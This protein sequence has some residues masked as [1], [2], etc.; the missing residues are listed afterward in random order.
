VSAREES[1]KPAGARREPVPDLAEGARMVAELGIVAGLPLW[2]ALRAA[3]ARLRGGA[4]VSEDGALPWRS[5]PRPG[6]VP[7]WVGDALA[8][9]LE[10]TRA[11]EDA[12]G[13][14]AATCARVAGELER[15][16]ARGASAAFQALRREALENQEKD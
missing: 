13:A 8:G 15:R 1:G 9:L 10:A 14:I 12:A 4:P 2:R 6:A 5:K 7:A 3:R 16:G 11:D